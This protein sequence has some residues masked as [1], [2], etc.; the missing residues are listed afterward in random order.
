MRT[1]IVP[2]TIQGLLLEARRRC[3][4]NLLL[5]GGRG[6]MRA[7]IQEKRCALHIPPP[8]IPHHHTII[9]PVAFT[10]FVS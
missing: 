10:F 6:V 4:H 9:T 8:K 2:E 3:H 5:R 1:T 7:M